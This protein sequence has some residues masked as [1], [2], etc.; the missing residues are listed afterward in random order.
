MIFGEFIR[1]ILK[2]GY[3]I[4]LFVKKVLFFSFFSTSSPAGKLIAFAKQFLNKLRASNLNFL[5]QNLK[6]KVHEIVFY[7][8]KKREGGRE[9][10]KNRFRKRINQSNSE[11]RY[12]FLNIFQI[13]FFVFFQTKEKLKAIVREGEV[14]AG[15][16]AKGA[17]GEQRRVKKN[18]KF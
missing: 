16:M 18:F 14:T 5:E 13:D 17:G 3:L 6:N 8:E 11:K 7:K 2:L 10:E 1:L 9:R 12:F 4:F 15:K